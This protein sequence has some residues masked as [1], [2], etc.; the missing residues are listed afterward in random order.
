MVDAVVNLVRVYSFKE[1]Q[2]NLFG[3]CLDEVTI[4]YFDIF[5]WF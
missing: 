2:S 5:S 3:E 4:L 1:L